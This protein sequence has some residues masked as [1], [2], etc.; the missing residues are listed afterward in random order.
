MKV[1]LNWL[2]DFV[3]ISYSPDQLAQKLTMA[4]LEVEDYFA[5]N[6]SFKGVK[7]GK[8]I[9]CTPI[10]D[11]D[12]L[13]SCLV[14]IG[15]GRVNVVCGAPNTKKG[16]VAP[17]ALVGARLEKVEITSRRIKGIESEGMLC[18][19]VELGLSERAEE[20]ME[21]PSDT[22]VGLDFE[23]FLGEPDYVF[24]VFITPNRADCQSVIGIA[25]VIASISGR[26]LRRPPVPWREQDISGNNPVQV[27]IKNSN[28]C[29]R[30]SGRF[31][32]NIRIKASPFWLVERLFNVGVRSINNVVDITNY[33]MMETGQPLHAF[34]YKLLQGDKIIV[35]T[36][37]K[38]ERFTTL[39]EKEHI[40]N[41]HALLICDT[42]KPVA[43]A[44]VMGGL[45]SEVQPETSTVFLESA[46][47]EPVGIRKTAKELD[48]FTESSRRFERGVDPNGTV[49]AMNRAAQMMIDLADGHIIGKAVD[50]YARKINP[51]NIDLNIERVNRLLGTKRSMQDIAKILTSIEIDVVK[52]NHDMLSVNVPTFR[53]DITRPVD[54]IEEVAINLGYD[55]I[56]TNTVACINQLQTPNLKDKFR[57]FMR[58]LLVALG[59][60]ETVSINLMPDKYAEYFLPEK[61][62]LVQIINPLS[63]D[64]AALRPDIMS[65]L[66]TII[67]YNRNRQN[68]TCRFFQIGNVAW[69]TE[70]YVEKTHVAGI[71]AGKRTESTWFG[72]EET[73]D[74]Y[75]IKGLAM[76]L[77]GKLGIVDLTL[78]KNTVGFW[79]SSS[80]AVFSGKEYLGCMGKLNDQACRLAK[81]KINDVFAFNF[82]FD[83]LFR[84]ARIDKKFESIS[85]YPSVPFDLAIVVDNDVPVAQ[86]EKFIWSAAGS[87]LIQVKIFDYYTGDQIGAGKKSIG[88]SLTFSSKERTLDESSV[89]QS[90]KNILAHL[91]RDCGAELRPR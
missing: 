33:I 75:D 48:I 5:V 86:I 49:Y 43:L 12:H 76:S 11:T 65:S 80:V 85:K 54:L 88:F 60:R 66:L 70:A 10:E 63:A 34:D 8:I 51:V 19:E 45:N 22:P 4:G 83:Q 68:D 74:F 18:S 7:I 17:I 39:D 26:Q 32:E 58:G 9:D 53:P 30:Y 82:D 46:Y 90:I 61:T 15:D 67:S 62:G 72:K 69:K 57:D 29:A 42:V 20:L 38:D 31:I 47:F 35:R 28:R 91:N 23:R 71:L 55:Y 36:A 87:D 6:R 73:F 27:I 64:L 14:D 16:L 84:F 78:K 21:L 3:D 37:L 77:L 41:E 1:T 89:E 24:D 2:K 44:G 40:L 13:T 59:L 79:D 50:N 25:R 56:P 52:S 81:I